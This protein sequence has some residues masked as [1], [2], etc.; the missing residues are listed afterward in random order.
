MPA[1]RT[2]EEVS[3]DDEAPARWLRL[4]Q[5]DQRWRCAA[6]CPERRASASSSSVVSRHDG[7]P[8]AA[9]GV[10]GWNGDREVVEWRGFLS[11]YRQA[12][13]RLNTCPRAGSWLIVRLLST[14]WE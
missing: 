10:A 12:A 5:S 3:R 1:A 4:A 14:I 13:G 7:E 11:R 9:R 2:N 6:A 8:L